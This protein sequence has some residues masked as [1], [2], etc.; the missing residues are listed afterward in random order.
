MMGKRAPGFLAV[1]LS[2]MVLGEA[3]TAELVVPPWSPA[4][5][6]ELVHWQ[7]PFIATYEKDGAFLAMVAAEHVFTPDNST[8]RAITSA[9]ASAS[10]ALVIVEGF[11]TAMG[12]SPPPLVDEAKQRGTP[13]A[14]AFANG[15]GLYAASLAIARQVPFVGGEP[16]NAQQVEALARKGYALPDVWFAFVVRELGQSKRSGAIS[17]PDNGTLQRVYDQAAR[18]VARELKTQ[19]MSFPNFSARYREMFGVDIKDDANLVK[20]NDPGTGTLLGAIAQADMTSRDEHLLATIRQ[21]LAKS[22]RV[23]VVYGNAHWTTL[24]AALQNELGKP[25][26][27]FD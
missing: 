3:T 19:P 22:K 13:G 16:T 21:A 2:S 7:T 17:T 11:P 18:S 1:A 9:F 23:L 26:I 10:P 20:R 15:E 24:S 25:E 14:S 4:L 27:R 5:Q 8:I 6:G 12:E